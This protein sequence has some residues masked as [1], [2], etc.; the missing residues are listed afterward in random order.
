M[1][2]R[3]VSYHSSNALHLNSSIQLL[4]MQQ[5]SAKHSQAINLD[6]FSSQT[7]LLPQVV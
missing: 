4:Q 3:R 6:S 2:N 1:S 5:S 7:W